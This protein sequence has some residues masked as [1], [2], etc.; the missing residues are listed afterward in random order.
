MIYVDSERKHNHVKNAE[1]NE[2][3]KQ[4]QKSS[5]LDTPLY[6]KWSR[7]FFFFTILP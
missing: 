5:W 2:K 6:M 1:Q 4:K 7:I 3:Q